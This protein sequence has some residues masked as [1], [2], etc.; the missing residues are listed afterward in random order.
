MKINLLA[1]LTFYE[2]Y[3]WTFT[4]GLMYYNC[5]ASRMQNKE[6]CKCNFT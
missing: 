2:S 3:K 6:L 5:A 1:H 4:G